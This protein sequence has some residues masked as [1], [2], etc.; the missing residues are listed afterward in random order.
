MLDLF[1]RVNMAFLSGTV[2]WLS[3]AVIFMAFMI[4]GLFAVLVLFGLV[5][6]IFR[7]IAQS[8]NWLIDASIMAVW[9][10]L[11]WCWRQRRAGHSA[12]RRES[13]EKQNIGMSADEKVNSSDSTRSEGYDLADNSDSETISSESPRVLTP[14]SD[15]D[16]ESSEEEDWLAARS[17]RLLLKGGGEGKELIN[18][19]SR[20][21]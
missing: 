9:V 11:K 12:I 18:E 7:S 5:Y 20:Q 10:I 21:Q 4:I 14:A 8:F 1:L 3:Y 2:K 13:D 6:Y 17:P 19:K 16:E 15:L